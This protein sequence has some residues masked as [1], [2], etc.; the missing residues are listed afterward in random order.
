MKHVILMPAIFLT[1]AGCSGLDMNNIMPRPPHLQN[2]PTYNADLPPPPPEDAITVDE[3][4]TATDEDRMAAATTAPNAAAGS[5]GVTVASLG[6]PTAPGFWVETSLVSSETQGR[7]QSKTTGRTVKVTL[8]PAS[9]GGSR[10][11]LSTLQLLDLDISG[12]HE[13]VVFGS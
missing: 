6:D 2:Q 12:L 8:R 3:L 4:D 9:G 11:S 5:L 10:V 13:L 1:L 7:V